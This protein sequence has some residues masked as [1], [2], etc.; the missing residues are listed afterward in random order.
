MQWQTTRFRIDLRQPKIMGIVNLTPDS[1]SDG[2]AWTQPERAIAHAKSLL[3]QGAD[4]LDIGAEST[5]PGADVVPVS[6][7]IKRLDAVLR[8]LVK[9]RVPLSVDT[10]KPAVMQHVL[11]LGVDAIND[12][13][14]MQ[15]SQAAAIVARHGECGICLMHM[16][17]DPLTMQKTP[18]QGDVPSQVSAQ[19]AAAAARLQVLGVAR[20]RL[21]IDPGI[22]FG[23]TWQDNFRLLSR[24]SVLLALGLPVLVGWSRK[25]S[26]ASAIGH[27]IE[28][29]E[30]VAASVAAAVLALERGAHIL[31]VHDVTQTVHALKVWQALKD[32]SSSAVS[33]AGRF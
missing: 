8:E 23:K 13:G 15:E 26:L 30:R 18:M 14:A 22:G 25:S 3:E 27:P 4:L 7:E 19:L 29:Q 31:R 33:E 10:R 28:P 21:V 1:F 6:E 20:E 11:D 17:G 2:G 24:Q 9:W 32:A 5:R 12:V 16:H